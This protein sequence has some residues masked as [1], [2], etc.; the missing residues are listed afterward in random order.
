MLLIQIN[1]LSDLGNLIAN[2]ERDFDRGF[3]RAWCNGS[4]WPCCQQ[5]GVTVTE[6]EEPRQRR[7]S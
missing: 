1:A 6:A 5:C 4:V 3:D 7:D 2:D